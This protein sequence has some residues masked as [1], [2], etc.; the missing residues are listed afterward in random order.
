MLR[1]SYVAVI[2]IISFIFGF[3]TLA[4]SGDKFPNRPITVIVPWAPGGGTDILARLVCPIWEKELGVKMVILNKPGGNNIVGYNA[5]FNADPDGYTIILGQCPNYNINVLFQHASYKM[6][7]LVF[8]NLFQFDT[9]NLYCSKKAPWKNLEDLVADARKR[10]GKIEVGCADVLSMMYILLRQF[11]QK[12]GIKFGDIIPVGGGGPLLREVVG[13][14]LMLG[15]QGCWVS[16]R[17]RSLVRGLGVRAMKRSPI[18]PNSQIFNA[19]IPKDKQYTAKEI[20][21]L[22]PFIKGFAVPVAFKKK[23]P[24]RFDILVKTFEKATKTPK[25]AEMIK[26]QQMESAYKYY[27]PREAQKIFDEF[28]KQ[29]E[30]NRAFYEKR[31]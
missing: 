14:H 1:R 13:G 2:L 23:Y 9:M 5:L 15:M 11:Q 18:W 3:S 25:F 17:A 6:N 19:V 12:A 22:P 26:Q 29:L 24:E 21:R 31:S 7:D 8:L 30:K 27:A 20:N 10:P 16:R 4:I 28:T